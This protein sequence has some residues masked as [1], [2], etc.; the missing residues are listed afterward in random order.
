MAILQTISTRLVSNDASLVLSGTGQIVDGKVVN[1]ADAVLVTS[2]AD[3]PKNGLWVAAVGAWTRHADFS[4]NTQ[5]LRGTTFFIEE[6]SG[7]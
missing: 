5:M 6:G 3:A 1:N 7:G 4:V 2:H